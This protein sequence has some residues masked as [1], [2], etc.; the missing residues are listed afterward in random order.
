V[1]QRGSS[2]WALGTAAVL[3]GLWGAPA[4]T[5]ARVLRMRCLPGLTGLGSAGHLALTFDDGPDP[6]GTPRV[7]DML[8][9]LGW[10]ATFFMLGAQVVRY[11]DV[12]ARVAESGHEVAVHGFSHRNHLAR[13]LRD[14]DRDVSR[15]TQMITDVTGQRPGWFRPPYG[16]L[17]AGS[18]VAARRA[19]L[20]PVL[21]SAWG[22]DW[23]ETTPDPVARVLARQLCPGGTVLLHDS[24]CTA[25]VA[26]S[27]RSAVAVL[28]WLAQAADQLGCTVGPL[29][30]HFP[31]V[32]GASGVRSG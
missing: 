29:R 28:P 7:L 15:A 23:Q 27:W 10:K 12:A 22:Q 14:V 24:D 32:P 6:Q 17:T 30:E 9:R 3:A 4:I 26:D 5:R 1:Q 18:L 2:V 20:R 31:P 25:A 11:P 16:V 13:G 19:A 8:D 21:W